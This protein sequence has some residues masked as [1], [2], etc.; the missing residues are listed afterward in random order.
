MWP[1]CRITTLMMHSV[2]DNAVIF[3]RKEDRV[4]KA[5]E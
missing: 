5:P 3:Y 4:R 1:Q 2:H